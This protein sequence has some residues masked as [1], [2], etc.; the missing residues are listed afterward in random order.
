MSLARFSI[1]QNVL[2][3]LL[4]VVVMVGG[5]FAYRH[6]PVD[7]YPDISL[8][9]A[10]ITTVWTGA[11]PEEVERLV[12]KEIE[13]E[14]DDISGIK[15]IVS[16]SKQD[17]S[18]IDVKFDE[19]MSNA[20]FDRAF[21]DLR[22]AL[23]RVTDLPQDAEEPRLIRLSLNEVWPLFQVA[24]VDEGGV[25]EFVLREV[26]RDLK[27]RLAALEGVLKVGDMSVR[28]REFKVL[29]DRTRL[30]KYGLTLAEVASVIARNNR[31]TPAGSFPRGKDEL[32]VR[33]VGHFSDPLALASTVIKKSPDGHH[34]RLGDVAKVVSGFEKHQVLSRHNG[35]RCLL[36][37]VAKSKSADST[38]LVRQA[39]DLL[40]QFQRGLPPG[41]RVVLTTDSSLMITNRLRILKQ[42][43]LVGVV[44][45]FGILWVFVGLR[46][47]LLAIVGIPFSFLAAF[48]F[49]PLLGLSINALSIF[50]LVLISGML[51]DDAIIVMEN[52][53]QRI[54]RG[55]PP[56]DAIVQGADQVTWPVVSAVTTTI[57]AFLPM[58]LTT[59]VV[60]EFFSIIPKT[61]VVALLASLFECLLILPVHYLDFGDRQPPRSGGIQKR[62]YEVL[63]TSYERALRATLAYRYSALLVVA[64]V[65]AFTLALASRLR[66]DLFPS[67]F[68]MFNVFLRAP[69]DYTLEQTARV[70]RELEKVPE[71]FRPSVIKEY[72]SYVGVAY[73]DDN[74]LLLQPNVAN[75]LVTLP[76][77]TYDPDRAVEL[78]REAFADS[79]PKDAYPQ[80]ETLK[81]FAIADGPPVG[82]PVS[83]RVESN[84]YAFA[85]QVAR[86]ITDALSAMPGVFGVDNNLK[87][88]PRQVRVKMEDARASLFG[89]TFEEIA[90]SVKAANDGLIASTFRDHSR[91]EDVDIRV[92][93]AEPFRR[94]VADMLDVDVR[95]PDGSLIKVADVARVEID[96]GYASLYHFDTKRTVKVTAD[97]NPEVT[98]SSEVNRKIREQFA[99]ISSR[100]P[101]VHLAFGGEF[102]ETGKS[103]RSM[104]EAY[105]VALLTIFLILAAQF[106]SYVQPLVVMATV[107]LSVMGV[108]VGLWV[109]NLAFTINTFIAVVGLA[110]VVVNDSLV[111]VDFINNEMRGGLDRLEAVVEGARKRVRAI[112]LTTVTTIGG[113]IPMALG[114]TGKSKVWGPFAASIVWGLSFATLLTLFVVPGVYTMVGD[115]QA[116]WMRLRHPAP[117]RSRPSAEGVPSVTV[118]TSR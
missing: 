80:I 37:D 66:V 52:I 24:L 21:N 39:K 95:A 90:T 51:V 106:R 56:V 33:A 60:G 103:F 22:A 17:G 55:D 4:F 40:A 92:R 110:G 29:V 35:R 107:P 89:L 87:S 77:G 116:L 75:I 69:S 74:I 79:F 117:R 86:E 7:V 62:L 26:A 18:V 32:Q 54:E 45:V 85:G 5:Y 12:T 76:P 47:S 28:D 108:V 49:Y 63:L 15:R 68:Q 3:N 2:V 113:L 78:L 13:E 50:S 20:D 64:C 58:L 36:L 101:G 91:D 25:G 71:R 99:D 104:G 59:G 61:I 31:N 111:L 84:D 109:Q 42:N 67:D 114:L 30:R 41:V 105:F 115:A 112:L 88:G 43:L 46:N 48:A 44:L 93:Y 96:R 70:V 16:H 19:Q 8:D 53:Y 102:E 57:A 11:S 38:S 82:K 100:Y 10:L 9:E 23:D 83:I 73:D 1:R 34:V 72:T 94:S 81:V 6:L 98:T 118:P 14:I 65:A 27:P 97:L